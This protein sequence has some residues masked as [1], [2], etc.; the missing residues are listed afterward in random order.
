VASLEDGLDLLRLIH[1]ASE[2]LRQG[3]VSGAGQVLAEACARIPGSGRG[4]DAGRELAGILPYKSQ[5]ACTADWPA[6]WA[7]HISLESSPF[8][9]GFRREAASGPVVPTLSIHA[10][11]GFELIIDGVRFSSGV[12]P[13]RKPLELLKVLLLSDGEPLGAVE[14]A[15]RLWP[16][17]DGDTGRNSLQVAV[18]RLRRLL[19]CEAALVMQ[20]RKLRLDG[21][22]W[23]VDLWAFER[24]ARELAHVP[25][26]DPEFAIRATQILRL[27][28]GHLFAHEPEQPWMLA[29]RDRL[30]RCWLDV[31]RR[32]GQHYELRAEWGEACSLYQR[33]V[34]LDPLDEE[35]YRRL[36]LCHQK[37]GERAEALHT[38]LRCREQLDVGLGVKP[39][40]ETERLYQILRNAA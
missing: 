38:Y 21:R 36:M 30:R 24:E 32:L 3:E 22:V 4:W 1:V 10:L 11:G 23:W 2:L 16:D 20:D 29:P 27:Y 15:D 39:S 14:L 9:R 37:A 12:K 26:G 8:A 28:R 18:H 31:V 33:T 40:Q 25:F 35:T 17:S 7:T 13:Q 6:S 5:L 19:G 34:D